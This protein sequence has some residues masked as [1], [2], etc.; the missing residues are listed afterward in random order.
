MRM[1]HDELLK[2]FNFAQARRQVDSRRHDRRR[3]YAYRNVPRPRKIGNAIR[4]RFGLP[5][6]K[7]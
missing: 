4:E 7:D 1:A 3:G 6:K 5:P 2:E